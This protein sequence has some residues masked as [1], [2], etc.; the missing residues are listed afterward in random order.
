MASKCCEG[1]CGSQA[2]GSFLPVSRGRQVS[3]HVGAL[4]YETANREKLFYKIF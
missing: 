2:L 3:V 1:A 4:I